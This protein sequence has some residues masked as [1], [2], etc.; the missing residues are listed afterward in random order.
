M[1]KINLATL[2]LA[3]AV[4]L[5]L[6]GCQE[7]YTTP[8]GGANMTKLFENADE[9]IKE[10]I[11]RTPQSPFPTNI[12][13]VRLQDRYYDSYS[14]HGQYLRKGSY[15]I[16]TT[17]DIEEQGDFEKI[18]SLPQVAQ[19]GHINRLLLPDKLYSEKDLRIAAAKMRADMLYIYTVDTKYWTDDQ[20][21]PLSVF[22]IGLADTVNLHIISTVSGVLFDV[23]TGYLY[24]SVEATEKQDQVTSWW[25]NLDEVDR[26]RLQVERKAFVKMTDELQKLWTNVIKKHNKPIQVN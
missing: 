19:I 20:S 5:T 8:G 25:T 10:I 18:A 16:I 1:K 15:T 9:E 24:G 3:I 22:T 14:S 4:T 21:K 13:I 17:R 2:T 7:N 12:A 11:K 23:R 6:C 26:A